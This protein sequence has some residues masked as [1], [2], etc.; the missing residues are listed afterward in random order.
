MTQRRNYLYSYIW[1]CEKN[2]EYWQSKAINETKLKEKEIAW[3]TPSIHVNATKQQP[4]I[5][6][7][8]IQTHIHKV[9]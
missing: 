9:E 1:C 5:T 8:E 7:Q 4:W 6:V 3:N 2:A